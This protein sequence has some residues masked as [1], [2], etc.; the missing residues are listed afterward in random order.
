MGEALLAFHC[1]RPGAAWALALPLVL[2]LLAR[3]L[4]RPPQVVVGTLELLRGLP[5]V[6]GGDGRARPRRQPWVLFCALGLL[7]GALA[8]LGPRGARGGAARTWTCVVDRS[9]SMGFSSRAQGAPTRLEAALE[10]AR[11]WLVSASGP[12]DRVRWLAPGRPALEL[13]RDERP[14]EAWLAP[15]PGDGGEPEWALHDQAGVLWLSDREPAAAR[16]HAGLFASG[17]EVVFG[18]IA[19]DGNTTWTW[20]GGEVHAHAERR[21]VAV[22]VQEPEVQEQ[23]GR[24]LPAVLERVLAA[25]C[26]ARGFEL[27]RTTAAETLLVLELAPSNGPDEELV[28]ERDGWRALARGAGLDEHGDGLGPEAEDWLVARTAA[29]AL[30]SVVRV[31]PGRI[32]VALRELAEPAGD[33]ALFALSFAR[34]FDRAARPPAGVVALAERQAAGA[35]RSAP[36][37]PAEP[38]TGAGAEFGP[39][40][41]AAL[42]GGAFLCALAAFLL[43]ARARGVELAVGRE[44]RRASARHQ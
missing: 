8:W 5:A 7:L 15:E 6:E 31:V 14:P 3:T 42:A 28:L 32:Q 24:G 36:G 37:E 25:W 20:E 26:G 29:G 13:V 43:L 30:R 41:D 9:P 23:G 18:A 17:G 2:L 4:P 12:D 40:L 39:A 22:R 35:P 34:L 33:P 27:A 21:S 11:A 16:A 44:P 38:G 10:S 19:A 1:A